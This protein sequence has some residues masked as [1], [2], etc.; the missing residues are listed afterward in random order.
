MC[1]RYSFA[2]IREEIEDR[3]HLQTDGAKY[4]HPSYNASPGQMQAVISNIDKKKLSYFHFG[5]IPSWQNLKDKYYVNARCETI[6][7]KPSFQRPVFLQRC[8]VPADSFY[9][10]KKQGRSLIPYRIR[11]KNKEMFAFAGIWEQWERGY[12]EPHYSFS[13]ITTAAKDEMKDI[14]TRMP[15]ILPQDQEEKWLSAQLSKGE[16]MKILKTDYHPELEIYPISP[17][18]N[19]V[20]NNDE[21]LWEPYD[22]MDSLG[23]LFGQ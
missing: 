10:W 4:Y 14:H 5:M 15:I 2:H 3:F 12:L 18:V 17:R 8:L 11:K 7:D 6:F 23:G 16:I 13:I 19:K 9:E 1:G 22:P 20:M 21:K